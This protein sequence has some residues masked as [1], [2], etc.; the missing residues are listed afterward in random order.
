MPSGAEKEI[1]LV[2][3][4]TLL[5]SHRVTYGTNLVNELFGSGE[6]YACNGIELGNRP[7][8]KSIERQ[9]KFGV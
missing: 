6:T 1:L 7:K 2:Y 9:M 8:E 4:G 5:E 3:D